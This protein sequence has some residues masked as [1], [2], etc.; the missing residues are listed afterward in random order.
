VYGA[1]TLWVSVRL[2]LHR[3]G[4]WRSRRLKP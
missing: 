4:I 3:R 2:I 1:K